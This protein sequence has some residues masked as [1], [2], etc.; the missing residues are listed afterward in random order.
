MARIGLAKPYVAKYTNNNGAV[1]YSD[2]IVLGRA[3]EAQIELENTDPVYLYADD[4]VAETVASFSSGTLTLRIDELSMTAAEFILG[5]TATNVDNPNGKVIAFSETATQPNLG[6][7]MIVT[8]M[9]NNNKVYQAIILRKVKF[10]IPAGDYTTQG[11]NIEFNT[12]ELKAA[13]MKDD[14]SDNI[15]QKWGEFTTKADAEAWIKQ[16]LNITT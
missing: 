7:G 14:T 16:E 15:W 6:L 2:G 10:E 1:S 4:A 13:V 9:Y 5:V 8:R 12:P 11:E 3:I